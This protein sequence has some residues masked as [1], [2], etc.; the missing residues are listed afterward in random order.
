MIRI[1]LADGRRNPGRAQ[2]PDRPGPRTVALAVAVFALGLTWTGGQMLSL[3][4]RAARVARE[5]ASSESE[6]LSLTPGA[7]RLAELEARRT[8]LSARAAVVAAWRE[9]RHGV[10]RLLEHVVRR[11]PV[12]VRLAQLHRDADGLLLGGQAVSVAAVSEFAAG[13]EMLEHVLPPVEIVEAGS[14]NAGAEAAIRFEIRARL[15]RPVS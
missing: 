5:T 15:A 1:N 13:L 6:L 9:D 12:G 7:R 2:S 3:R 8:Q 4:E 11:V 10:A 14:E